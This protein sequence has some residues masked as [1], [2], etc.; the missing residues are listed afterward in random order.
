[1]IDL[2]LGKISHGY[3]RT[4]PQHEK[5]VNDHLLLAGKMKSIA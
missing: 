5:F 3:P 1:M 4:G 2:K